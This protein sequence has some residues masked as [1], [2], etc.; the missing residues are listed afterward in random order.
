M[1]GS[2]PHNSLKQ[3]LTLLWQDE[4]GQDVIEYAL[5]AVAMG[6]FTVAGIHGLATSISN[7][8]NIVIN[9]FNS[10]TGLP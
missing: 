6:L 4:S 3:L 7:D 8:L 9:A 10:A 1:H 5:V 2:T